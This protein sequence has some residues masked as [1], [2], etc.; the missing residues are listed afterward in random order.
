MSPGG[1]AQEI[2]GTV[3]IVAHSDNH[4]GLLPVVHMASITAVL[5]H[6]ENE[7][8][9]WGGHHFEPEIHFLKFPLDSYSREN[10][11]MKI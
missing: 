11:A 2:K 7:S 1:S 9:F 3:I 4:G 5:N 8:A 10:P 6:F